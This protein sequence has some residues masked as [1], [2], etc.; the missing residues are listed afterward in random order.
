MRSYPGW[1]SEGLARFKTL[2]L[3]VFYP[4]S[5]N[6]LIN[7]NDANITNYWA[8]WDLCTICGILAIGVL[9]D[10][11]DLYDEAIAY[12]KT[13]R[14]TARRRTT[15]TCSIPATSAS[16]RKAGATRATPRSAWR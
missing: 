6:F 2:M 9:C 3:E 10:R 16:G 13:G 12:Y 1:S 15:S 7:H 11:T 5:H 8:N 4:L 14:A